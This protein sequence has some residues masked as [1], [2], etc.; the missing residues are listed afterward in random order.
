MRGRG[1]FGNISNTLRMMKS[2]V[3]VLKKD[4]ELILFPIFSAISIILLLVIMGSS[5]LLPLGE[6]QE[7]SMIPLIILIFVAN[8]F[9]VFFNSALISAAL[10]RL[11]GGDP[12][13]NSG[14]S[15]ALKHI[16]HIFLWSIIVTIVALLI[17]AIKGG[18]R[19]GIMR[20]LLGSLLQAG[21]A[22]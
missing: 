11:R 1:F 16:H 17:A 18:R 14:I 12:N 6:E 4:K 2:C 20:N 19:D 13:V 22:M 10:E 21:W 15:H 5:G 8:F 3:S 9:I 7:I